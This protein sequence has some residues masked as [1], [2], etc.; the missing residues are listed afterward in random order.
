MN[1]LLS[2]LNEM[3]EHRH[4]RIGPE[5]E[6]IMSGILDSLNITALISHLEQRTGCEIPIGDIDLTKL[7]TPLAIEANFLRRGR[8]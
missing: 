4:E 2:A 5:T 1:E 3:T 7:S 8:V 6:L